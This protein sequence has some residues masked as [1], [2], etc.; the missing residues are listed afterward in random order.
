MSIQ[1]IIKTFVVARELVGRYRAERRRRNGFGRRGA[2]RR[3]GGRGRECRESRNC[4][5]GESRRR[6]RLIHWGMP[7]R[8]VDADGTG[9]EAMAPVAS[10]PTTACDGVCRIATWLQIRTVTEQR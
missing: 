1:T 4:R 8:V 3:C 2:A 5:H 7:S 6:E 9:V 10:D